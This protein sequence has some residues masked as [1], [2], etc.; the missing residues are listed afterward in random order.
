MISRQANLEDKKNLV[1]KI[2]EI[3]SE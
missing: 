1:K 3:D 2:L